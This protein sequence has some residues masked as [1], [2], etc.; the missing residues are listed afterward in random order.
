MTAPRFSVI[1]ASGKAACALALLL[2]AAPPVTAGDYHISYLWHQ[3][4]SSVKAYKKKLASL[5]GPGVSRGLK[6][7]SGKNSFGVIYQRRGG[8]DSARRVAESHSK[9]L[10]RKGLEPAVPIEAG[11]WAAA[12]EKPAAPEPRRPK[13]EKKPSGGASAASSASLESEVESYIKGL[14]RRGQVKYD[15][16]T[17]WVVYDF[18][19]DSK[20]VSINEDTPLA[21]ASLI[22]PLI[23]LAYFHEVSA[24][25]KPYRSDERR[26]MERMIKDSDNRATNWFIRRLGGPAAVHRLLRRHYGGLLKNTSIVEY[27]PAGGRTFRNRASAHDYSRF[28]YALW[29]GEIPRSDELKRVMGLPNADRL[30]TATP[31][32][33]EGT[34]VYDKT[35][36]TS[37]LCGD[38]GILVAQ[39]ADGRKFPYI[40]I[41][42][43]EKERSTRRYYSWMRSRGD[44]I[45]RVSEMAYEEIAAMH[46]FEEA[47]SLASKKGGEGKEDS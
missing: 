23:A 46:G 25:R 42:V 32:V 24:G 16:K 15:E 13:A 19:T 18:T 36:S 6:V 31:G 8:L 28:L 10:R 39:R 17:A 29:K 45:R 4:L 30:Y 44:V 34:R 40:I 2:A 5:L 33:P 12:S 22:K 1:R 9:I 38:I 37:R 47:S 35:G 27:I 26:R 43:I 41:G 20:L 7:V 21:A 11:N 3:D 14:R